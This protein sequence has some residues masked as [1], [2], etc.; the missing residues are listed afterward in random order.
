MS[1]RE[2][3]SARPW[4]RWLTLLL[5]PA[6]LVG[7]FAMVGVDAVLGALARAEGWRVALAL[8]LALPA[9]LI[10]S[11]RWKLLLGRDGADMSYA[12]VTAVFAYAVFVGT[13]TPGRLGELFKI[14]HL[15][16]REI[17][18]G[19]ALASVLL[20]RL[21][22]VAMLLV[23]AAGALAL[24]AGGADAWVGAGAVL[25]FLAALLVARALVCGT[26]GVLLARLVRPVV[27]TGI[28]RRVVELRGGLCEALDELPARALVG[29]TA[30]TLLGWSVNYLAN[31]QL[32]LA[33]LG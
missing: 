29:A 1:D 21:L 19:R 5:G 8:A 26:P 20:D 14:V 11:W 16:Q 25:G 23:L 18:T 27:P 24:L 17:P 3:G 13:P 7:L 22:D 28:V 31:W 10:R 32:A 15:R 2:D 9:L 6:A 4:W 33:P 30:L 12:E